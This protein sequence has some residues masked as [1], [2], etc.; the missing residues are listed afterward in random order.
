M[1]TKQP[2]CKDKEC[3][4]QA[5]YEGKSHLCTPGSP[6]WMNYTPPRYDDVFYDGLEW[7]N[8]L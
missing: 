3:W 6:C 4:Q 2:E 5:V 1:E 8:S 7:L